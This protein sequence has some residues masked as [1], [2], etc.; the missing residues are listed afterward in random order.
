LM[1]QHGAELKHEQIRV[2][3]LV[4]NLDLV[5]W[6]LDRVNT[7]EP[8]N[9]NN[10]RRDMYPLL[11]LAVENGNRPIIK[12]LL[13][14]GETV[15]SGQWHALIRNCFE[16]RGFRQVDRKVVKWICRKKISTEEGLLKDSIG[17][18]TEDLV[19]NLL[20]FVCKQI[21]QD[22]DVDLLRFMINMGL[23]DLNRR[24][25]EG[26]TILQEAARKCHVVMVKALLACGA[27]PQLPPRRK[28]GSGP[29]ISEEIQEIIKQAIDEKVQREGT[30]TC[31]GEEEFGGGQQG[32]KRKQR[33]QTEG[34]Q[35]KQKKE[36]G[37]QNKERR[38]E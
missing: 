32:Q 8:P 34:E 19:N 20:L 21:F 14:N 30:K 15:E 11:G 36:K 2:A 31:G 5:H 17:G 25:K 22:G 18:D 13:A 12:R 3:L 9:F 37:P 23:V 38:L 16:T 10:W 27:E 24:D 6:L 7:P 28:Q 29:D 35:T 33:E 26:L 1:L 4:K